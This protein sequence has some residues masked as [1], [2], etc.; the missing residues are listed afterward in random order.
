MITLPYTHN[1][2]GRRRAQTVGNRYYH[3]NLYWQQE[4]QEYNFNLTV[5]VI[6][7]FSCNL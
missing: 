6:L 7:V 5:S 1:M 4:N 2:H 3:D